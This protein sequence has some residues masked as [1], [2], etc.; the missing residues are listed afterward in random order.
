MRKSPFNEEKVIPVPKAHQGSALTTN[1]CRGQEI[2]GFETP[3]LVPK[4]RRYGRIERGSANGSEFEEANFQ[5]L[6]AEQKVSLSALKHVLGQC[7]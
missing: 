1:L 5:Y 7:S 6:P 2:R 3:Q 4:L